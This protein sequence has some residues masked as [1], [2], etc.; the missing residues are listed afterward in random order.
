MVLILVKCP[1]CGFGGFKELKR[2]RYSFW[3]TYLHECP[4]CDKKFRYN[5]DSTGKKSFVVRL[6]A[7]A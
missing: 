1:Y 5:L 4:R 3:G 7:Y 2:W 6:G